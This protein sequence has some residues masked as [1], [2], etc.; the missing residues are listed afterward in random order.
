MPPID[1]RRHLVGRPV[2]GQVDTKGRTR[3]HELYMADLPPTTTPTDT[4]AWEMGT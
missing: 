2:P 3:Y 4:K 1:W